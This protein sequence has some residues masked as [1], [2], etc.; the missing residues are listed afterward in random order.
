MDTLSKEKKMQKQTG[1]LWIPDSAGEE[2]V[3]WY[4]ATDVEARIAELERDNA[5]Y[6]NAH[7]V[8]LAERDH[9]RQIAEINAETIKEMQH[10]RDTSHDELVHQMNE[11][12]RY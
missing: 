1:Y 5:A 9:Y 7:K 10:Q 2:L 11:P 3:E 4:R 12:G 8:L 6:A